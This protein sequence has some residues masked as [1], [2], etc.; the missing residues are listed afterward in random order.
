[1]DIDS[2]RFPSREDVPTKKSW[3]ITSFNGLATLSYL[4]WDEEEGLSGTGEKRD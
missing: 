2:K 4:A 3:R 1:M